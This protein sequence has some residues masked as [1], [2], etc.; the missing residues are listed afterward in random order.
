VLNR[1]VLDEGI[2]VIQFRFEIDDTLALLKSMNV[3][4]RVAKGSIKYTEKLLSSS[5]DSTGYT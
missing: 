3:S 2:Y 5:G 1:I 4:F